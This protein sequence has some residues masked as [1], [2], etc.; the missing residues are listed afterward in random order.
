MKIL[1][2][3]SYTIPGRTCVTRYLDLLYDKEKTAVLGALKEASG[4]ALTTDMWTSGAN[5]GYFTLTAHF[6]DEW[7]LKNFVLATREMKERHTGTNI[8]AEL[9]TVTKEFGIK[10]EDVTAL[11][12]DNASN[13]TLCTNELGWP[14]LRCFAHT[15]Q[16]SI[17]SAFD[18]NKTITNTILHA[19]KLVSH[20]KRSTLATNELH[21]VQRDQN[22]P[23]HNLI[24]DCP[25]RWNSTYDMFSRL[26][27]QRVPIY[28]VLHDPKVIKPDVCRSLELS[29]V[30]WEVIECMVPVLEPLYKATSVMCSEKYPTV[31]S[32]VPVRFRLRNNHLKV[33][34][35][36]TGCI[37]QFKLFI[38]A[39]FT[40][41]FCL[42]SDEL[43]H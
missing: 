43:I 1:L 24:I 12:T 42:D 21:S 15:L 5:E 35:T 16:L 13:M 4:V 6:L 31:A 9:S 38:I 40:K 20:F 39:D 11:V 33:T 17:R 3:P 10:S 28:S 26:V 34:E 8:A 27:E 18:S 7:N 22:I 37:K 23:E 25:T 32:V 29:Q 19:K 2:N 14:H 30:Q 36:D 41:R